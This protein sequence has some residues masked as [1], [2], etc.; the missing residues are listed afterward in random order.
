[1]KKSTILVLLVVYLG[2][3]LV[4]GI[5][6]MKAV[7]FEEIVYCQQIT[8]V[9]AVT[10]SGEELNIQKHESE[11]NTYYVVTKYV[12]GLTVMVNYNLTPADCTY[13]DVKIVIVEPANPPA[14]LT[15]RGEI[16]FT[17]RGS[18]H[19]KYRATDNATGPSMDFWIYLR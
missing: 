1:M 2:S 12:E 16:V 18:V 7:P 14:I 8:P 17:K 6:G 11:S 9:S 4:V 10:S 5:F 3:I 19:I 15:D 13:K